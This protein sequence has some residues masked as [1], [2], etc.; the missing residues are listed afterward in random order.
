MLYIKEVRN[1]L[2]LIPFRKKE[3]WGF[4]DNQKKIVI[5]CNY[6]RAKVISNSLLLVGN[7]YEFRIGIIKCHQNNYTEPKFFEGISIYFSEGVAV[8]KSEGQYTFIDEYGNVLVDIK[9]NY[10]WIGEFK[11]G[12]ALVKA[13][14]VDKVKEKSFL[15]ECQEENYVPSEDELMAN[16][17]LN[18]DTTKKGFVDLK[19]SEII[20]CIYEDAHSFSENFAPVK[21]NRKW[22]F[23]NKVGKLIIPNIYEKAWGFK[24][25]MAIVFNNSKYGLIDRTG[26]I[27]LDCIYDDISVKTSTI[28]KFKFQNKYGLLNIETKIKS[29]CIYE[30]IGYFREGVAS[31]EM[32]GKYGF[33]DTNISEIIP[34]IYDQACEFS[35]DLATVYFKGNYFFINKSGE[36]IISLPN[37]VKNF[38]TYKGIY[39]GFTNGFA[40]II[41]NNKVGFI[42]KDGTEKI[43]CIYDFAFDFDQGLACVEMNHKFGFINENGTLVIPCIYRSFAKDLSNIYYNNPEWEKN[44]LAVY[45]SNGRNEFGDLIGYIDKTGVEYWEN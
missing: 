5:E 3:K 41:R 11:D 14:N 29:E 6:D 2:E 30:Y 7:N 18:E 38:S 33:I 13:K 16:I 28:R 42:Q 36:K 15:D 43:P 22:G 27:I 17:G 31:F 4:S 12:L 24:N 20:P 10:D 32:N 37:V 21:I 25:G 44:L 34:P 19:G 1:A 39:K 45:K 8:M 9:Q 23:I 40:Q 26:N 35:E